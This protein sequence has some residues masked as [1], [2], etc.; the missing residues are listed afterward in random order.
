MAR[1][2]ANATSSVEIHD[3]VAISD[4][5]RRLDGVIAAIVQKRGNLFPWAPYKLVKM[6]HDNA[7]GSFEGH[8]PAAID[9]HSLS[10]ARDLQTKSHIS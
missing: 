8:G 2:G 7:H 3:P 6:H 4:L 10:T 1:C 5:F 9:W